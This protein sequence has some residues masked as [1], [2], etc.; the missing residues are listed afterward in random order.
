[1]KSHA[2]IVV[3]LILL[4]SSS[5]TAPINVNELNKN[6]SSTP[7]NSDDL[8]S[9]DKPEI[10]LKEIIT[11]AGKITKGTLL[12]RRDNQNS[13]KEVTLTKENPKVVEVISEKLEEEKKEKKEN[14]I[15]DP[16]YKKINKPE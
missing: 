16:F 2:I 12:I 11:W 6:K 7:I 3:G 13:I 10:K 15:W 9:K 4:S 1:M 8:K 5:Q 14:I